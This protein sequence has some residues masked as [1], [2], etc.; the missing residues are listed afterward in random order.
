METTEFLYQ[1]IPVKAQFMENQTDNEQKIMLSHFK[2]LQNL[3][4]E[5]KLVLAGP[6]L[7]ASFGIVILHNTI[8]EEALKIMENDPAIKGEIM[9]GNLYPFR[10]S[11]IKD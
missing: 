11:L 8:K 7:D 5:G 3:L 1:I 2:Y 9:T 4:E 10:V 6:C